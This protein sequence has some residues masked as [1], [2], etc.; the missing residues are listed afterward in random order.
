MVPFPDTSAIGMNYFPKIDF[1]IS[2]YWLL[3]SDAVDQVNNT[4]SSKYSASKS[5]NSTGRGVLPVPPELQDVRLLNN[6]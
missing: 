3:N 6:L 2:K 4:W 1:W 5:M